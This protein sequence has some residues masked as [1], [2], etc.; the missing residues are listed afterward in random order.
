MRL[1]PGLLDALRIT[2]VRSVED[3]EAMTRRRALASDHGSTLYQLREPE[4]ARAP[5][6][7]AL[8]VLGNTQVGA[9]LVSYVTDRLGTKIT[10]PEAHPLSLCIVT[11]LQGSMR[12]RAFGSGVG[13]T[14]GAGGMLLARVG[15][16]VE[17][18]TADGTERLNLWINERTLNRRLETALEAPLAAPLV[19]APEQAWPQGV[20]GSLT[21]LVGYVAA[22]LA[23]PHSLFAGGVGVAMFEDLVIRTLLEGVPHSYTERLAKGPDSAPPH[24]VQR[25]SAFMRAH[26]WEPVTVEDIARAAGCSAR[27]LAVAFRRHREQT[28]TSALRDLRLDAARDAFAGDP[29]LNV[30]DL[31]ARL[32]FSNPGRFAAQYRERF[33]EMPLQTRRSHAPIRPGLPPAAEVARKPGR[34]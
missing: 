23:D 29:A 32:G 2:T 25:A 6:G 17:A 14:A 31:A 13:R 24:A 34:R 7:Q 30:G 3:F 5:A 4:R 26:A 12:F 8:T 9:M 21:R 1:D 28:V 16:G 27:A 18:M 10:F 22:E 11:V 33:G 15:P 20:V 19:F